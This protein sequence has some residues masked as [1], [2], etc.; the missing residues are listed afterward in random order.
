MVTKLTLKQAAAYSGVHPKTLQRFDR[1]GILPATGRTASNRRWYSTSDID[2]Y[3]GIKSSG[4]EAARPVAYCRVSSNAQRPDLINQKRILG[5]FC[6]ARGLVEVEWIE[7]I[8]GGLNFQR[9][10]FLALFDKIEKRKVSHLI[11]AHKDRLVRFGFEWFQRFAIEH[12]CELLILNNEVLSPEQE[13]V[14]DLMTIT[15]CFSA[16]LYGLRNYRKKL[17]EALKGKVE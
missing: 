13:M 5:E 1:E 17:N 7:E 15:D 12:G 4:F 10:K 2:A 16:R 3:F 11:L 8:A 9:P 6:A 14:Q